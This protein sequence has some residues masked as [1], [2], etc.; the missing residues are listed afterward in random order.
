MK[1]NYNN[2]LEQIDQLAK[3]VLTDYEV[4]FEA[5][6][7]ALMEEALDKKYVQPTNTVW[8]VK[9]VELLLMVATISAMLYFANDSSL[10]LMQIPPNSTMPQTA[11]MQELSVEQTAGG[12]EAMAVGNSKTVQTDMMQTDIMETGING[13]AKA[14][15][16]SIAS[17]TAPT[18]ILIQK[19]E[20][21][22]KTNTSTHSKT[23]ERLIETTPIHAVS[24]ERPQAV[25]TKQ[26]E[27]QQTDGQQLDGQQLDGQRLTIEAAPTII[28]D[29]AGNIIQQ[30]K[31]KTT[32]ETRPEARP[33]QTR[34]I[35]TLDV[36]PNLQPSLLQNKLDIPAVF[37]Q[38]IFAS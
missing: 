34:V 9:G 22:I 38:R 18:T 17:K 2:N 5:M 32:P 11:P 10:L 12:N 35:E 33:T 27:N 29:A 13:H 4:P 15:S 20:N 31:R 25:Q 24:F 1:A 23:T 6:N 7:W 37:Q 8:F 14:V 19:T 36:L 26:A 3:T 30:F 16:R 21:A 28:R